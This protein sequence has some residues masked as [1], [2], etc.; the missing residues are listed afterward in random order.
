MCIILDIVNATGLIINILFS[1][2]NENKQY[3][4]P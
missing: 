1:H 3:A 2:I 4:W